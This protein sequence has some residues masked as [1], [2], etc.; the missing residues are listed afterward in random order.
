[1]NIQGLANSASVD[2]PSKAQNYSSMYAL[3]KGLDLQKQGQ[4]QLLQSLPPAP[5]AEPHKGQHV[6]RYV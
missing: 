4:E 3:I 2:G 1:M 5:S 6:D